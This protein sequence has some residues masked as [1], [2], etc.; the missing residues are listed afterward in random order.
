MEQIT[1][2]SLPDILRASYDRIHMYGPCHMLLIRMNVSPH[3]QTV[4]VDSR[5][6][7]KVGFP[8]TATPSTDS[9]RAQR[10]NGDH[11][12]SVLRKR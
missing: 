8:V 4:Y 10:R 9:S 12:S 7:E 1:S 6:S 2:N 11:L 5:W 3:K